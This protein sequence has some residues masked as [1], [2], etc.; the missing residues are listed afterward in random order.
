MT[1]AEELARV[2][3]ALDRRGFLRLAGAMAAAGLVPSGCAGVPSAF[4][5]GPDVTLEA[6]SPREYA[7]LTAAATQLVGPPGAALIDGREVDVGRLADALL[8]T[9]PALASPIGQALALL[10]FGVWPL[11]PKVRTFT[12]LDAAGRDAVLA[13]LAASR[14]SLKRVLFGGVRALALTAFYGAPASRALTGY[15]GPFGGGGVGIAAGL[16]AC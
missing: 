1:G 6:L 9:N 3:A 11:L 5:P 2:A 4:A 13:D 12:G 10:E 15:P 8:A 7:T 16:A 14:V